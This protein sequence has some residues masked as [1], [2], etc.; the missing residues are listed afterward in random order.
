MRHHVPT[1]RWCHPE[2]H[3][4]SISIALT[5]RALKS[6]H[7]H[8]TPCPDCG[9][10]RSSWTRCAEH[11]KE[12]NKTPTLH[13]EFG[14]Y[15]ADD[16]PRMFETAEG[17]ASHYR[18]CPLLLVKTPRCPTPTAPATP[19]RVCSERAASNRHTPPSSPANRPACS[20]QE[21]VPDASPFPIM[22]LRLTGDGV[23]FFIELG[24]AVRVNEEEVN[25]KAGVG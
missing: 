6:P 4:F 13:C 3:T 18:L 7:N 25:G 19:A 11:L 9:Q 16:T 2:G 10:T 21:R 15:N 1:C 8:D 24:A 23:G 17:R 14:C 22:T 20:S 5:T 12:H